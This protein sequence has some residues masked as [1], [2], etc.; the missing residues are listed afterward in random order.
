[1]KIL[2][3]V[4]QVGQALTKDY[5]MEFEL[6]LLGVMGGKSSNNN[7]NNNNAQQLQMQQQMMA[8][9]M[10]QMQ[11]AAVAGGGKH[12]H[13]SQNHIKSANLS[14]PP[15][16]ANNNHYT[17]NSLSVNSQQSQSLGAANDAAFALHQSRFSVFF[18]CF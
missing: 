13:P 2:S 7:S 16:N 3:H 17:S 15:Y 18:V 9:Q 14:S 5:A 12:P 1:M 6:R 4:A 10:Q 8:M 11:A